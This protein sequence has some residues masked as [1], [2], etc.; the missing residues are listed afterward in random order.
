MPSVRPPADRITTGGKVCGLNNEIK[1]M[2]IINK[3]KTEKRKCIYT[4]VTFTS[5]RCASK[6]LKTL[7]LFLFFYR[8][9]L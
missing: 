9:L 5:H 8:V 4:L 7:L 3:N 2:K 6:M 1:K